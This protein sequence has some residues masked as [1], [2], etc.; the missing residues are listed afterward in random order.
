MILNKE[1][2]VKQNSQQFLPM[3]LSSIVVS[4]AQHSDGILRR[5]KPHPKTGNG[6]TTGICYL[7]GEVKDT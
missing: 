4:V 1:D 7:L 3:S 5:G 6:Y 2:A